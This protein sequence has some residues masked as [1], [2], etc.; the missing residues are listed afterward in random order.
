MEG[1]D[2]PV[3]SA[4]AKCMRSSE[5]HKHPGN[6]IIWRWNAGGDILRRVSWNIAFFSL[7]CYNIDAFG[8]IAQLVRALL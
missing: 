1:H 4:L 5:K 7:P 8:R 2:A 3:F 6:L